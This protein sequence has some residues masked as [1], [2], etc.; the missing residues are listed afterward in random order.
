M[1]TIQAAASVALPKK[2]IASSNKNV[3]QMSSSSVGNHASCGI[4]QALRASFERY[5]TFTSSAWPYR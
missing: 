5:Q 4:W 2:P 3:T 1:V